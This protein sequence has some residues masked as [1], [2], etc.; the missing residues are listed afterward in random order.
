VRKNQD[1]Q[2]GGKPKDV[3]KEKESIIKGGHSNEK[4]RHQEQQRLL[5]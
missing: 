3:W 1:L 5:G 4:G 2:H